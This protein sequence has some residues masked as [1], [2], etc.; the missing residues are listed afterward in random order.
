MNATVDKAV[1]DDKR[2]DIIADKKLNAAAEKNVD[3]DN[4]RDAAAGKQSNAAGELSTL[5]KDQITR[6]MKLEG[7]IEVG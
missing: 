7:W 1:D 5:I 4:E 2:R 3:A 6:R